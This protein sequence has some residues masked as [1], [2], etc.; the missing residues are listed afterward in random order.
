MR[1]RRQD[2]HQLYAQGDLLIE[3]V[4]ETPPS[5]TIIEPV[6]GVTLGVADRQDPRDDE[7]QQ[8]ER[9]DGGDEDSDATGP[10]HGPG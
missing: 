2:V 3:R 7:A 1:D 4:N 6:C 9:R 10:R 8:D 5:G